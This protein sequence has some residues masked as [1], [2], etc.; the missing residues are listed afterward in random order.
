V[1]PEDTENQTPPTTD[2]GTPTGP[3]P[4]QSASA[5]P[6]GTA[7][8]PESAPAEARSRS[9]K[10]YRDALEKIAAAFGLPPTLSPEDVAAA[11]CQL[12]E[13]DKRVDWL[14]VGAKGVALRGRVDVLGMVDAEPNEDATYDWSLGAEYPEINGTAPSPALAKEALLLI[15]NGLD[16]RS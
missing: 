10:G 9:Y 16:E 3:L 2:G 15:V 6:A 7:P 1:N 12:A 11:L 14:L 5:P 4:E 13:Q 8:A